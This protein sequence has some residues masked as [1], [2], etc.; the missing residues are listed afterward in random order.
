MAIYDP[1]VAPLNLSSL[2]SESA[3][4]T[5]T[6]FAGGGQASATLLTSNVNRVSVA[7]TAGD[8]VKLPASNPG[9]NVVIVNSGAKPIQVFGSGTDTINDVATATGVSQMPNS[10]VIYSAT[11]A[12][13]WYAEGIGGGYAGSLPTFST[14]NAITAFAGGGQAS[15]VLLTTV[16]NRVTTVG[17]AA[18][19][20]KLPAAVAGLSIT[21]INAAAANAM[22][23]FPA[24]GDAINALAANTAL[25]IVANKTA[26]FSCAVAG[27]WHS[28]LTA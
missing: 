18:D 6:A 27:Q 2:Q 3:Q 14:T 26:V 22:N 5:F 21:V 8:S 19:S 15:A 9:L 13:A 12:G 23:V 10:I 24:T 20:V 4:D 11:K 17:T 28:V 1:T 7:A 25:S 16:I